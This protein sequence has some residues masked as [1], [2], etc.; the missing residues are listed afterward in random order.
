MNIEAKIYEKFKERISLINVINNKLICKCNIHN[1]IFTITKQYV[2]S[3]KCKDACPICHGLYRDDI[4]RNILYHKFGDNI[5]LKDKWIFGETNVF[6]KITFNCKIHGDF[7]ECLNNV[8][9]NNSLGCSKCA[10]DKSNYKKHT[11]PKDDL[12]RILSEFNITFKDDEFKNVNTY[13]PFYKDDTICFNTR[14]GK[15]L[16]NPTPKEYI[17]K[18]LSK[19]SNGS[20][21]E[22]CVKSI[23]EKHNILFTEQKKFNDMVFI[24][25]LKLD[26]FL[27]DLNIAIEFDGRQHFDSSSKFYDS[28]QVE[29]DDLKNKYCLEN[30]IPL[31]RFNKL[32]SHTVSKKSLKIIEKEILD[33]IKSPTTI[34]VIDI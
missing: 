27:E 1:H 17:S 4:V 34:K 25:N 8:I 5:T 16:Y 26:F 12:R 11:K 30:N 20:V 31:L 18:L 21:G 9:R 7:T 33:F 15:I 32:N 2:F 14:P 28:S 19:E 6:S 3:K 24:R 23:L 22:I 29:R 13:M 10:Y